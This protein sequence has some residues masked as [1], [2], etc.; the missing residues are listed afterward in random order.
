MARA[1]P[2]LMRVR[3]EIDEALARA[4]LDA[5]LIAKKEELALRHFETPEGSGM[6]IL[7]ALEQ[8]N[9][10]LE[11]IKGVIEHDQNS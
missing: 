2:E 3:R 1:E 8:I 7:R 5:Y 6:E 11:E 9:K 4:D 10:K